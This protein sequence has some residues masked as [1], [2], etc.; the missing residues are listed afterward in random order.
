MTE[1]ERQPLY[2]YSR[3]THLHLTKCSVR[4]ASA[5]L[6]NSHR[7]TGVCH[8]E[9]H[10]TIK[11]LNLVQAAAYGKCVAATTT[12]KQ[13]LRRDLC[14]KEFEALKTCFVN[15]VSH[16]W[17]HLHTEPLVLITWLICENL[18]SCR[19]RKKPNEWTP[20][21]PLCRRMIQTT[22][23]WIQIKKNHL[24]RSVMLRDAGTFQSW[25]HHSTPTWKSPPVFKRYCHFLYCENVNKC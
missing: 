7:C 9:F 11:H 3:F 2:G 15:A 5:V 8:P 14:A 21:W 12:G 13:E 4:S 6:T 18:S 20:P 23:L 22:F 17:R 16:K 10:C 19:P 1:R 24:W 25:R